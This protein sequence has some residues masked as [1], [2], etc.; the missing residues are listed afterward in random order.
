MN[1][2]ASKFI[3]NHLF[4]HEKEAPKR[5]HLNSC[6]LKL[7]VKTHWIAEFFAYMLDA[8]YLTII[9]ILILY[10]T[11]MYIINKLA[12]T[13]KTHKIKT[14]QRNRHVLTLNTVLMYERKEKWNK[15]MRARVMTMKRLNYTYS[16]SE[17]FFII[18]FSNRFVKKKKKYFCDKRHDD[19]NLRHRLYVLLNQ[20]PHVHG[21]LIEPNF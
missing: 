10:V 6:T 14:K 5:K 8:D 20:L 2:W 19:E 12:D 7:K 4:L 17:Y 9:T 15:W 11:K 21:N 16:I 3:I 1:P 13:V 18:C